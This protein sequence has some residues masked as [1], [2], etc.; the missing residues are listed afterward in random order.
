M[1]ADSES[2]ARRIPLP[3]AAGAIGL[4]ASLIF[5][6]GIGGGTAFLIGFAVG[7]A[8]LFA[9][10]YLEAEASSDSERPRRARLGASFASD[11]SPRAARPSYPS[12]AAVAFPA[13]EPAPSIADGEGH[14]DGADS[15][16]GEPRL[17]DGRRRR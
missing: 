13:I 9:A 1:S 10:G 7:T 11:A 16:S 5:P 14:A 3:I 6:L 15:R 17:T 12:E 8:A 4:V 2:S